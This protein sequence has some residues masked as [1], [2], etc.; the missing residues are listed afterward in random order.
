MKEQGIHAPA[1]PGSARSTAYR[2]MREK[3]ILLSLKPGEALSDKL[4]AEE[5]GMSRTP[6]REAIL[7]LSLAHMVILRPQIGTFVAPIDPQRAAAEQFSR[8]ALEK[9][10]LHRVCGRLDASAAARY[11]ENLRAYARAAASSDPDRVAEL[12]RLD[13]AFHGIAF[14]AAGYTLNYELL[15][16]SL[17]H[18]ERLRALSLLLEDGGRLAEDHTKIA[19][20]LLAG[21]ERAAFAQL[22]GHL[23][24][25]R[26]SLEHVRQQYPAYLKI[27]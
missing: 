23:R 18:I 15:L 21:D 26:D 6:V 3:I 11:R 19:E 7:L 16:G 9:E 27:G 25:Y 14:E 24:R 10:I 1:P 17:H 12:L 2:Y 20:A 4:I 5:L 22:E 8:L 13:N